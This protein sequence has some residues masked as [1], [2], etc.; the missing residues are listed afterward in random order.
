[1]LYVLNTLNDHFLKKKKIANFFKR[2]I[3]YK[4]LSN[5]IKDKFIFKKSSTY[6]QKHLV[7][8]FVMCT[9]SF[10]E[11]VWRKVVCGLPMLPTAPISS[12]A[13]IHYTR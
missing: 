12:L 2:Q 7:I 1:M 13:L 5:Q 3:F 8:G 4:K 9:H 10:R 6:L 11:C